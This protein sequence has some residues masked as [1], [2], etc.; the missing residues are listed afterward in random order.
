MRLTIYRVYILYLHTFRNM[1]EID[2]HTEL[3][4]EVA[5]KGEK[6]S[7]SLEVSASVT[8]LLVV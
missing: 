1:L 6:K 4:K 2:W 3:R 5:G 8:L 7:F